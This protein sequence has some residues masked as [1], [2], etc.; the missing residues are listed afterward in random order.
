[1]FSKK[2]VIKVHTGATQCKTIITLNKAMSIFRFGLIRKKVR[3]FVIIVGVPIGDS[4]PFLCQP[5]F[6]VSSSN[7]P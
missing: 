1:M 4:S 5:N 7:K 6:P 2:N 3:S